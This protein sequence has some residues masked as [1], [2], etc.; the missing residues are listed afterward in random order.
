MKYIDP[1]AIPF[2]VTE[3]KTVVA[4]DETGLASMAQPAERSTTRDD[5]TVPVKQ[6][7]RWQ[8]DGG[9]IPADG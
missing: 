1:A 7:L 5:G 4:G 8:D 9:A 2:D 3:P 6:L